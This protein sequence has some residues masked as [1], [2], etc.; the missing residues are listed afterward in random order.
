MAER[1]ESVAV[2]VG[3]AS[4][5]NTASQQ[6][7]GRRHP[8]RPRT[9]QD[10]ASTG[11]G[12]SQNR[13][14][15]PHRQRNQRP[16]GQS[17]SVVEQASTNS[18]ALDQSNGQGQQ[19]RRHRPHRPRNED[20]RGLV[21]HDARPPSDSAEDGTKLNSRQLAKRRFGGTLTASESTSAPPR[22]T[23]SKAQPPR[24]PE[25]EPAAN[26]LTSHLTHMLKTP[27][28]PDCPI[29]YNPIQPIQFTWSCSSD[30]LGE[31]EGECCWSTFHMKCIKAWASKSE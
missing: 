30:G 24:E 11:D 22:P 1:M 27:P 16:G 13:H 7:E 18:T 14:R 2:D 21:T 15:P 17:T 31:R 6:G 12:Q 28:Y 26:D 20:T 9:Q 23:K 3:T 29:C 19:R 25:P 5:L 10:S 4:S 8:R